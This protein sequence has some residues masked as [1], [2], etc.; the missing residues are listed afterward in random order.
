VLRSSSAS[1]LEYQCQD[2]AA[3]RSPAEPVT[4]ATVANATEWVH[5]AFWLPHVC[6][7]QARFEEWGG[8][9]M[10]SLEKAGARL[11]VHLGNGQVHT[12][13]ITEGMI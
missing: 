13:A 1:V 11:A 9:R 7:P 5:D 10:I 3:L 6:I 4:L 12:I 2:Q 8:A